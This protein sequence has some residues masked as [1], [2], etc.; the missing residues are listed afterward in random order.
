MSENIIF[1]YSSTPYMTPDVNQYRYVVLEDGRFCS[2]NVHL[3]G[4]EG[5]YHS[6]D[7]IKLDYDKTLIFKSVFLVDKIIEII[8]KYKPDLKLVPEMLRNNDIMDGGDY[9]LRLEDLVFHGPNMLG[10]VPYKAK[11]YILVSKSGE[12]V[13]EQVPYEVKEKYLLSE[14]NKNALE[15]VPYD[16]KE[17]ILDSESYEKSLEIVTKVFYEIQELIIKYVK[18]EGKKAD[19]MLFRRLNM[20][21]LDIKHKLRHRFVHYHD[22]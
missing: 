4:F 2:G 19:F 20:P 14:T 1:E 22:K 18:F 6:H 12:N 13:L 3:S 17:Y 10:Q 7:E 21:V 15:Q 8:S 5:D 9:F 11:G 16:L